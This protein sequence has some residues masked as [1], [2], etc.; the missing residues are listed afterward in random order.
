MNTATQLVSAEGD[1]TTWLMDAL[2]SQ[3]LTNGSRQVHFMQGTSLDCLATTNE[4]TTE[5]D[6][7]VETFKYP[8]IS[9]L[10]L[11]QFAIGLVGII[12][13]SLVIAVF[14][15]SRSRSR[16]QT[17]LLIIHQ[18]L[19]DL[20]SSLLLVL[21][22][23]YAIIGSPK[24]DS[25]VLQAFA[26]YV[27]TRATLFALFAVST[28]N[29][30]LI[31]LERYVATMWPLKYAKLF[32]RRN[33]ISLVG[34]VWLL[35]PVCQYS[36]AFTTRT[37]IDGVC[38]LTKSP[39]WVGGPLFVWEYL[40][41]VVVMTFAFTK[42]IKKLRML[43]L[44]VSGT[45]SSLG[46]ALTSVNAISRVDQGTVSSSAQPTVHPLNSLPLEPDEVPSMVAD[47]RRVAVVDPGFRQSQLHRPANRQSGP[48][49]NV[50]RRNATRSLFTVYLVY[51]I[52]W[53]P[54]QWAFF[55][56][57]LGGKL[58]FSGWFYQMSVVLAI[59]NTCVNPFIYA[60]RHRRYKDKLLEMFRAV[61]D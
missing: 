22:V 2:A 5:P 21:Y 28:F 60:F 50:K 8:S 53:S 61:K 59:L 44:K 16:N 14:I 32:A 23:G 1:A 13:N 33:L 40:L 54:N 42:T 38:I 41:P 15:S 17:N 58:N 19:V 31:S 47:T 56:L 46:A 37:Y 29:L 34:L 30:T 12:G 9:F 48:G 55:Q 36:I 7:M 25:Q 3:G 57:S 52:C 10:V 39:V 45:A 27:W 4:S 20:L 49:R 35:A 43:E 51:I 24:T 11:F 18:A 6:F 26:C